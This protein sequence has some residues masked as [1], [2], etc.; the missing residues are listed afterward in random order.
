MLE[1][2][3][4]AV[5][6]EI[7]GLP[8]WKQSIARFLLKEAARREQRI[9]DQRPRFFSAL[10]HGITDL[11]LYRRL[12]RRV[13]G[14]LRHLICGGARLDLAVE[15]FF[16]DAGF[17]VIQGYGLTE[18]SPVIALNPIKDAKLGTVGKPLDGVEVSFTEDGEL[19]T[20]GPHVMKGYYNDRAGT[21][22]VFRGDW[23]LTGDLCEQDA[24]GY[25][26]ISGR[27]KE[28]LVTSVGKNISPGPLEEKLQRSPFIKQAILV[29]EGRKFVSALIVPNQKKLV[30][31]AREQKISFQDLPDLL[32]CASI[33]D[34]I[35]GE[36]EAQQEGFSGYEKVRKFCFLEE[37]I[38]RD[39][40]VITPTRKIR[41]SVLEEKYSRQIDEL[42]QTR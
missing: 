11:L 1:K 20:R 28:I 39:P 21:R 9:H 24:D 8:S 17:S 15:G 37:K 29:G 27:K 13:G 10:L 2:I 16:R 34:L 6:G 7:D 26:T 4:E 12:R 32:R 31:Y 3:Q 14:R 40:E 36:I 30:Q 25:L 5:M 41:R 19:L 42:Y 22:D 23:L 18:T 33:V 38:F 35:Q